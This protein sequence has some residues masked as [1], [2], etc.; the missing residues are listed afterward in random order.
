MNNLLFFV[1]TDCP[2]CESMKPLVAKLEFDTGIRLDMRDVWANESDYRLLENYRAVVIKTDPE[3]DG[4]PF[5]YDRNG[6]SYLCGEVN[7]NTL[8]DWAAK[9]VS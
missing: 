3:C 9:S 4:L 8:K 6:G 5:F 2:H 1:G 7:Y